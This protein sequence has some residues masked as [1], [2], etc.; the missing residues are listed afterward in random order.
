[1]IHL[2]T[3]YPVPNVYSTFVSMPSSLWF[4]C[5]TCWRA[6]WIFCWSFSTFTFSW[7]QDRSK[8]T[9]RHEDDSLSHIRSELSQQIILKVN[10]GLWVIYG[11]ALTQSP[12][13]L[14]TST[15]RQRTGRSR[16]QR[17]A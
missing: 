11:Y 7:S 2:M 16:L 14:Q 12:A 5:R 15:R 4:F 6:S 3:S 13:H 1:M 9:H 8:H 10:K 17:G